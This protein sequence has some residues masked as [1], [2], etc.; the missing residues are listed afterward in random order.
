M[1]AFIFILDVIVLTTWQAVDPMFRDLEYFPYEDPQDTEE[2]IKYQ[3]Q[4]EHCTSN[5]LTVWLGK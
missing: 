5:N 2:D 1:L 3:P 4:L